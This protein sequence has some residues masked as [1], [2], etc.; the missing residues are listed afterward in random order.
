MCFWA[1][2]F[3]SVYWD[4]WL[5]V[6]LGRIGDYYFIFCYG[7]VGSFLGSLVFFLVY[8]FGFGL[9]I[10]LGLDVGGEVMVLYR[11]S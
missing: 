11:G 1:F 5:W 9:G 6:F 4:K 2:L 10:V 8:G 3:F 7:V